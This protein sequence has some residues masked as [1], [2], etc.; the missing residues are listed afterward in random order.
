MPFSKQTLD[1]LVEN[2]LHDSKEWYNAHKDVYTQQ[3][4]AP[5]TELVTALTPTMLAIDSELICNP[6]RLSRLYR[7]AR[8]CKGKSI[9]RDHV[10]Y[11]FCRK[12]EPFQALPELYFDL[13]PNGFSY[14][15]G[16]YSISRDSLDAIRALI[17]ADDAAYLQAQSAYAG[18]DIFQM[19]GDMYKKNHYPAE[20]E[21]K[22]AWLN[23]KSIYFFCESTDFNLLFSENLPQVLAAVYQKLAPIYHFFYK[24]E[25][26]AIQKRMQNQSF[27]TQA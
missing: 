10:W 7:D 9:F 21:T 24:A 1:F 22:C 20:S 8:F 17:L 25:Q 18:Q 13:S 23:R 26:L 5:F 3:L 14:G 12:K 11:S 4:V 16:Y 19:G 27:A 15:C 6:K 2:Q